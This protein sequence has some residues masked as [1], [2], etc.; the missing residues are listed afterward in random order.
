[1]Q[2][3]R[4]KG[5]VA[6]MITPM[7]STGDAIDEGALRTYCRFLAGQGLGAVF[8]GGTTGE[9]AALDGSERRRLA[10][11]TTEE[12]ESALPV[13][14][15]TGAISTVETVALSRHAR[16]VGAVGIAVV[17][18]W[19]YPLDEAA[20]LTHFVTV[21]EA[22]PELPVWI[23]HIPSYARNGVTP[24]LLLRLTERC[25]NIVGM[26]DSGGDLAFFTTCIESV[27]G[28][29]AL[30]GSDALSV[31]ALVAGG[32][33][34]VSGNASAFPEIF[35]GLYRAFLAGNLAEARRHQRLINGLRRRLKDG[36][37]LAYFKA[38]LALRGIP[39]GTTR[40]PRPALTG[41]EVTALHQGL[42]AL[43][44]EF[45]DL[46]PEVSIR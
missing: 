13:I 35:A 12:L 6:A 31:A 39:V 7:S 25:G 43:R 1:M 40:L 21:A 32:D 42:A 15:H 4:L 3:I 22:V 11:I 23:Y 45:P 33:G 34:M 41:E 24:A 29:N 36:A 16:E 14:I 26:K 37:H 30:N 20:L 17:T 46:M 10:E 19:Y 5:A 8:V 9:F 28:L 44:H 27:P 18:P 38:A 2:H